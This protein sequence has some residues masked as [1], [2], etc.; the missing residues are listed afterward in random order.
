MEKRMRILTGVF[1]LLFACGA[2]AACSLRTIQ[3]MYAMSGEAIGWDG[4]NFETIVTA[5]T[6]ARVTFN[7]VGEV[8]V[9]NGTSGTLG[10][11]NTFTGGGIYRL[12]AQCV[13]VVNIRFINSRGDPTRMNLN[14]IV[15]GTPA[16]PKIIGID[17]T[18]NPLDATARVEFTKI[19][20]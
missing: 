2:N 4:A 8:V 12:N 19:M 15:S 13:G 5:F 10:F 17:S 6:Q 11:K 3:G 14:I 18:K 7:G 16:A 1:L 20:I 9:K